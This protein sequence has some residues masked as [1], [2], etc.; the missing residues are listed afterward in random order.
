MKQMAMLRHLPWSK[1]LAS[2]GAGLL[3]AALA[4]T[5]IFRAETPL[6]PL[7]VLPIKLLDTSG[8]PTDQASQH[9][10]RLSSL[11][12]DLATDL[13]RLGLYRASALSADRLRRDCPSEEVPCLLRSAQAHGAD[14]IFV[15]V[16]HKS[17]TLIMQLWARL[18]DARTGQDI[19]SRDLNFRGDTDEA[20]RRA[21]LFL[22]DQIRD[23][24]PQLRR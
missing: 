2:V 11:A 5:R 4:S 16:V 9:A 23:E 15:G 1:R 7:A 19:Y 22:I 20:W 10:K 3:L 24:A 21:E 17:S 8:E 6:T 13:T 18:V 14:L 12:Q